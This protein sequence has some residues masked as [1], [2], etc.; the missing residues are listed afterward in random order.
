MRATPT[1]VISCILRVRDLEDPPDDG[2]AERLPGGCHQDPP[3]RVDEFMGSLF[4]A[5]TTP[6]G[7]PR[8][9]GSSAIRA[10]GVLNSVVPS[11]PTSDRRHQ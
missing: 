6:R 7:G 10:Y 9:E 3:G 11:L 2:W 8:R 1:T 5:P 4:A